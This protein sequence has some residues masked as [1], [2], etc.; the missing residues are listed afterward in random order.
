[1]NKDQITIKLLDS[2][3]PYELLLLADPSTK[4]VNEYLSKGETYI[5]LMAEETIGVYVLLQ[6]DDKT[7]EIKN[8][9][10]AE[11]YQGNGIGKMLL[12]HAT[13]EAKEKGAHTLCIGTANSSTSQINLYQ[14]KGFVLSEIKENFFID[15]YTEPI[16]ENG[17]Q[18]AHLLMFSKKL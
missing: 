16:F 11:K 2:P 5:A 15:N 8:I 1:M 4:L 3:P 7:R 6:R 13:S 10:V 9:A 18:A 12:D 14:K 17:T